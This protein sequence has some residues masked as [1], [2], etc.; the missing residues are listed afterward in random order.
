[1][2]VLTNKFSA[3]AA[4]IFTG[5]LCDAKR[6]VVVGDSRTFGKGTVL[7]VESLSE[8][9]SWFRRSMPAGS[10]TFEVAMFFRPGGD[11]VQQLGIKPDITLPALTDEIKVGEIYLENHLPWASIEPVK[12]NIWDKELDKKVS[13]LKE[14]SAERI[15]KN[16]L[17]QTYIRQIA[18]FR[19][20]RDRQKLSLNEE[21]RY[22]EYRREKAVSDEVERQFSA[23]AESADKDKKNKD[24]VLEEAVNIA[25]DLSKL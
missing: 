18:L 4:E 12:L 13:V 10:L 20:I 6:A 14:K 8:Y 24:L 17:Y 3:S 9:T 23:A 1:M 21:K 16:Q 25:A 7:Q 11:S 22:A 2:V 5:A 15:S 19:E